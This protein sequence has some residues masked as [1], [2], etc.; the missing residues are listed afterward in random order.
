MDL[1]SDLVL[2]SGFELSYAFMVDTTGFVIWHPAL[3]SP[4]DGTLTTIRL[5]DLE[6]DEDFASTVYPAMFAT[7]AGSK[8]ILTEHLIPV[9]DVRFSGFR[10]LVREVT[11][12]WETVPD[13]NFIIAMAWFADEDGARSELADIPQPGCVPWHDSFGDACV[14]MS[15][16]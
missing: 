5:L 11:Y 12:A 8:T 7:S 1:V 15:E 2:L 10:T 9:G 13:T 16:V 4:A 3:P 14:S 6:P